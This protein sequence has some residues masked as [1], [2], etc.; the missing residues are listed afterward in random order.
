MVARGCARR[1]GGRGARYERNREALRLRAAVRPRSPRGDRPGDRF[2]SA[3]RTSMSELPFVTVVIP[4]YKRPGPLRKAIESVFAQDYPRDRFELIVV[5]S[6][7]DTDNAEISKEL[8]PKATCAYRF[9]HLDVAR[10]P[11]ISRNT[12]TAAGRGSWIAFMD[13]DCFAAP[14]WLRNSIAAIEDG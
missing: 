4:C 8:E 11:G 5:D 14:G 2:L 12:G 3:R 10:G 1:G 7:P 6:S 13:S 9:I